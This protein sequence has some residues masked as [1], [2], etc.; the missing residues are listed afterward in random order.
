M[1]NTFSE[2]L[3]GIIGNLMISLK[4]RSAGAQFQINAASAVCKCYVSQVCCPC[5][6]CLT[7]WAAAVCLTVA[8]YEDV[9]QASGSGDFCKGGYGTAVAA[10]ASAQSKPANSVTGPGVGEC[11]HM[12]KK[13]QKGGEKKTNPVPPVFS[14]CHQPFFS[15]SGSLFFCLIANYRCGCGKT[16]T[17]HNLLLNTPASLATHVCHSLCYLFSSRPIYHH[18]CFNRV[19]GVGAASHRGQTIL[20]EISSGVAAH[21]S[22]P[23]VD[24]LSLCC[25]L[26]HLCHSS[27]LL[28]RL[29]SWKGFS[30]T[31]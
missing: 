26:I 2:S 11:R 20:R 24:V 23:L 27:L 4:S 1:V 6:V 15:T 14:L 12:P 22:V 8:G 25:L 5:L 28:V 21:L 18:G 17:P 7:L 29:T 31:V 10:A 19:K 3:S 30:V 13:N 16:I 9:G